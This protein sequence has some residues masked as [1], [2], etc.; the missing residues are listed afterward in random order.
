MQDPS[1]NPYLL[2]AGTKYFLL[3]VEPWSSKESSRR[4]RTSADKGSSSEKKGASSGARGSVVAEPGSSPETTKRTKDGGTDKQEPWRPS[5][6]PPGFRR[7]VS[8]GAP[9]PPNA[10]DFAR[11]EFT[12]P[13]AEEEERFGA[14]SPTPSPPAPVAAASPIRAS[15]AGVSAPSGISRALATS[16]PSTPVID[17]SDPFAAPPLDAQDPGLPPRPRSSS[18]RD[19]SPSTRSYDLGRVASEAMP[20]FLP[21]PARRQHRNSMEV[22]GASIARGPRYPGAID[23][24][25]PPAGIPRALASNTPVAALLSSS[26]ASTSAS[27]VHVV[28]QP[29]SVT[30]ASGILSASIHRRGSGTM[31]GT[32]SPGQSVKAPP[33]SAAQL[34]DSQW[35]TSAA[36]AA[37]ASQRSTATK[38]SRGWPT[39]SRTPPDDQSAPTSR[40]SAAATPGKQADAAATAQKPGILDVLTGKRPLSARPA[41]SARAESEMRKLLGQPPM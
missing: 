4:R 7:T 36:E 8:E 23:R 21:S 18:P 14:E 35:D 29:R 39:S 40:T 5:S 15:V 12:I 17:G 28:S 10:T 6:A 26:P 31:L 22:I 41:G 2:A 38:V 25:G 34:V 33:T 20:A 19:Y 11:T 13:E 1:T 27:S 16:A 24:A 3:E 37:K 9:L 32:P 30:S